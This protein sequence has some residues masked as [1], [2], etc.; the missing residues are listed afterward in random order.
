M[1]YPSTRTCPPYTHLTSSQ[2]KPPGT[3]SLLR[4]LSC[5]R[6]IFK[7]GRGS[8]LKYFIKSSTKK[9]NK[10]RRQEYLPKDKIRQDFINRLNKIK[11]TNLPGKE[12][13]AMVVKMFTEFERKIDEFRG[14]S[15]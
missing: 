11:L 6:P 4:G 5:T 3:L 7:T 12:F 14:D 13:K 2:P 8:P 1:S 10:I 9:A 15:T